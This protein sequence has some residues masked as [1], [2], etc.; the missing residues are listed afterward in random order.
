MK[1]AARSD[2]QR[3]FT[4]I[5]LLVAIAILAVIA[6]LSWR[7]LD[8]IMRSREAISRSME[9]ERVLAQ[10]F[11]QMRADARQAATDDQAGTA[12]VAIGN[13]ELR[14]VRLLFAQD[15]APRLQVVRYRLD[16]GRILRLASPPIATQGQLRSALRGGAEGWSE[17]SLIGG[18]SAMRMRLFVPQVGWTRSMADVDATIAKSMNNLKIPGL[19]AAPL[20]RAATGLEV[21]LRA[22]QVSAPLT[23]VLLIGE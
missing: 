1:P 21:T 7:G 22:P 8:S 6:V 17:V 9:D 13:G 10:L 20:L 5:E 12:A 2:R 23:R 18:V 19:N 15:S 11:D 16:N 3:G 14:I 4:L